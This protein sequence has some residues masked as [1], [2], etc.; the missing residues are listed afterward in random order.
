VVRLTKRLAECVGLWLAEGDRKSLSEITFTNNSF[1]LIELFYKQL[2]IIFK[3]NNN[4]RLYTYLPSERHKID[5]PIRFSTEKFYTDSRANK[6]Y[7]ILRLAGRD[8]IRKWKRIVEKVSENKKFY[9]YILRGFFAGEG[10]IKTGAHCNRTIRIAQKQELTIINE[11]LNSIEVIFKFSARERAYV[12][13]GRNNWKKFAD[14][15]IADLHPIKNRRFWETY[16]EFVEWHYSPNFI[17]KNILLELDEPKTSSELADI[18]NRHQSRI[19]HI[20]VRLKHEG[21]VTN[22]RV[23][24]TNYWTPAG[25]NI[26]IISKRKAQIMK[27]LSVPHL[28]SDI[29][30]KLGIDWKAANNRLRELSKLGLVIR[31]NYLWHKVST[32]LEVKVL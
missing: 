20:L 18:F 10:N 8:L 16:N 31:K 12:I 2:K 4:F 1:N 17:L 23:G 19:Q 6:P 28:T 30:K 24:S 11:I 25:K 5:L 14:L 21:R 22:F 29:S 26:I 13:T 32:K 27:L 9:I 7:F 3:N 15:R